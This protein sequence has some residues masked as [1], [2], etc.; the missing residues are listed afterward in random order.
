M[1]LILACRGAGL[2]DKRS[3]EVID[4]SLAGHG[5]CDATISWYRT[6]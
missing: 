2:P 5:D 3:Q 1:T 4:I 6:L